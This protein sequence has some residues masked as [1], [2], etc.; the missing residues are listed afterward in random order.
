MLNGRKTKTSEPGFT[1]IELL[2]VIA[3]IAVLAALLLPAVGR[4]KQRAQLAQCLSNFR[5]LQTAWQM[6]ANDHEDY[7]VQAPPSVGWEERMVSVEAG[8]HKPS[9]T[10]GKLSY[11]PNNF[12]NFNTENLVNPKYSAFAEYIK[13]AGVYRCPADRSMALW[14]GQPKLRVRS[15]NYNWEFARGEGNINDPE[16]AGLGAI[17]SVRVYRVRSPSKSITF[18]E[19][20]E[21]SLTY[22]GFYLPS[23]TSY[24]LFADI[25]GGRHGRTSAV[26]FVDGHV[27]AKKWTDPRTIP[28]VLGKSQHYSQEA[29][30]NNPDIA[31]L[32]ERRVRF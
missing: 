18:I 24:G 31:W 6:Y 3:I 5:Q 7:A 13:S 14:Q 11:E 10:Q 22:P 15:Y 8:W 23:E 28:P 32:A 17:N 27:E 9:W 30:V 12:N 2:V 1:L 25:P 20:H 26:G 21:D 29:L 19:E 4:A 16:H